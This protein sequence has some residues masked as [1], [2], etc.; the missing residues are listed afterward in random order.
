[1]KKEE[2]DAIIGR[3]ILSALVPY[4]V[5]EFDRMLEEENKTILNCNVYFG[6]SS[7]KI[8]WVIT[9]N[10]YYIIRISQYDNIFY[11]SDFT[12]ATFKECL[13]SFSWNVNGHPINF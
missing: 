13:I 1:M 2:F 9:K 12:I 8:E 6:Y 7:I 11:I 3:A 10:I 4:W 5:V